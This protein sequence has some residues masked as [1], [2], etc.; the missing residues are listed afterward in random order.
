MVAD[1]SL[2]LIRAMDQAVTEQA[3]LRTVSVTELTYLPRYEITAHDSE[4]I[5]STPYGV[6]YEWKDGSYYY[7]NYWTLDNSHFDA[8]GNLS[9]REGVVTLTLLDAS[10]TSQFVETLGE[11]MDHY[12]DMELEAEPTDFPIVIFW[13]FFIFVGFFLPIP[14]VVLGV[15]F[16][17][18]KKWG[19]P[20]YWYT[21]VA[22]GGLWMLTA[23]VLFVLLLCA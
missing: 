12:V 10:L 23:G 2:S 4:K 19:Y 5:F 21:V 6:V 1:L 14:F 13:I 18:R 8:N 16:A 20:N 11:K 3:A 9:Y 17:N 22:T 15:V 7:V